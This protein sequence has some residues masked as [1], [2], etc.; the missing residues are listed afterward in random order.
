MKLEILIKNVYGNEMYYPKNNSAKSFAKLTGKKTLSIAD[1]KIA[2][3]ELGYE[4]EFFID[5]SVVAA[6]FA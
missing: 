4:I 5:G 3:T 6:A 1:L 2:E